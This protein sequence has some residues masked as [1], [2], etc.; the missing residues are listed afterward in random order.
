MATVRSTVLLQ[1][2]WWDISPGPGLCV[3]NGFM[4]SA[5]SEQKKVKRRVSRSREK[6][7]FP[8]T[9]R[10]RARLRIAIAVV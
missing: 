5:G 8:V 1:I 4:I 7:K 6:T 3:Q 10:V 2:S 9:V